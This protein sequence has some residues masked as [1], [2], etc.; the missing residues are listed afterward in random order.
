MPRVILCVLVGVCASL[1]AF[2][3]NAPAQ[4]GQSN[5]QNGESGGLVACYRKGSVLKGKEFEQLND[6]HQ[7][8][9]TLG[10][11]NSFAPQFPSLAA[12]KLVAIPSGEFVSSWGLL[13]SADLLLLDRDLR[14]R[15]G[16]FVGKTFNSLN[17]NTLKLDR[18][19][20]IVEADV[21]ATTDNE[22]ATVL[23][24]HKKAKNQ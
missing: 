16:F 19:R 21:C 15:D 10:F 7:F 18:C 2:I 11:L 4:Q 3:G 17:I 13:G 8:Y 14:E 24:S 23:C 20:L 6:G 1:L 5:T 9:V 12:H 22:N